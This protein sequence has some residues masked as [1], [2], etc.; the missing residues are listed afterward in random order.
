MRSRTIR[1]GSVGL[2]ILA[3]IGVFGGLVL[4][5]LGFNPRNRTYQFTVT[6][7]EIIGMESGAAV[8]YRGS[9]VGKIR[10]VKP[11]TNGIDVLI[12]IERADLLIPQDV[13][14]EANQAGLISQ[15]SVDITPKKVLTEDA[16]SLNPLSSQCPS[17]QIICHEDRLNGEVGVSLMELLRQTTRVAQTYSTPEFFDN[18][19]SLTK[20]ASI[21]VGGVTK[22]TNELSLLSSSVRGELG[23]FSQT[24]DSLTTTANRTLT[25]ANQTLTQVGSAA[26]RFSETADTIGNTTEL[27]GSQLNQL[28]AS[29]NELLVTNRANVVGGL[30]NLRQTSEQLSELLG[31]LS[32]TVTKVNTTIDQA[33]FV[34]L[35]DNFETLSA[36]AAAASENFKDIST[37]L[38]SQQNIVLLQQTLESARAT[39]ANAQKITAD[40]DD[41]TGDP[42]FRNNLKELVNGL[43]SLVSTTQQLQQQVEVAQSLE[44]VSDAINT[45]TVTPLPNQTHQP[46]F[47]EAT[48]TVTPLPNQTHQPNFDEATANF[49][50]VNAIGVKVL[51]EEEKQIEQ[52][53][54]QPSVVISEQD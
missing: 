52:E 39:F 5:L 48:A 35:I 43:G 9:Q 6:F 21:A 3:G 10:E 31:D 2:L 25:Q 42:D 51:E 46:N 7:P 16:L 45:A 28:M 20:N 41:L 49:D 53:D 24:A 29:A 27:T 11:G 26:E 54:D 38:N 36:N 19:N 22:L 18:V 13:R 17:E 23:G 4:W 30:D 32:T 15:T 8:R 44:P 1:E 47:D 50:E 34:Q 12:E 37:S 33:K 40:L 14:I